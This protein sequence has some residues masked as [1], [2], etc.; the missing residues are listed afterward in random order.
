MIQS[1]SIDILVDN[2]TIYKNRAYSFG[3]SF[4]LLMVDSNKTKRK[5]D[6]A[7]RKLMKRFDSWMSAI[8]FAEANEHDEALRL[9]GFS[10]SRPRKHL[11]FDRIMAAVTF[12]EASEPDMARECMGVKPKPELLNGL[13]IPGVKI[14]CG[15]VAFEPVL[16]P[17]VKV[18]CGT[19]TA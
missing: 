2:A 17:G 8:T 14:W 16:I 9:A 6:R 18:W 15:S 11:S 7:M 5:E 1:R 3:T 12:A 4:A 19:V 13:A 10:N